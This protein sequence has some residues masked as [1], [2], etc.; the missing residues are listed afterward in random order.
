MKIRR[1]EEFSGDLLDPRIWHLSGRETIRTYWDGTEAAPS[2]EFRVGLLYS[3]EHLY[4]RF[5]LNQAEELVIS[6][7]P[8]LSA[9]AIGLWERD[10]CEIFIA[11][12]RNEPR[13]YFEFEVAPTGE[14]LDLAIDMTSGERVTDWDYHSGMKAAARIEEDRVLMAMKIPWEAFGRKPKA[15]DI[16]LGNIFRC[17]GEGETRGYLAWQPTM[18]EKPNFHVPEAF[19]EFVFS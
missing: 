5:D 15:G 1:T 6:T 4:A 9:K 3:D 18:T 19:G 10:V 2:G 14:W 7:A 16:W 8:D 13:R 17:V 11:P 12:D